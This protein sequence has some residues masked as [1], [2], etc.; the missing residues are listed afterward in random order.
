MLPQLLYVEHV[1]ACEEPLGVHMSHEVGLS[2]LDLEKPFLL[3]EEQK[4]LLLEPSLAQ[5]H[6]YGSL[7]RI[8]GKSHM[9][10]RRHR[11]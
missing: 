5:F 2:L 9:L 1:L 8:V 4:V 11:W 10:L 6:A 7:F 3:T